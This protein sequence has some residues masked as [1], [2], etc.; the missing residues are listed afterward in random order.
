MVWAA[1]SGFGKTDLY[2]MEGRQN[3]QTYIKVLESNLLPLIQQNQSKGSLFQQNNCP[4]HTAA[5][6]KQWLA[7]NNINCMEWPACSPDL[8]PMENVWSILSGKVYANGQQFHSKAQ[9]IQQMRFCWQNIEYESI[10]A[11][12]TSMKNITLKF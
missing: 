10:S 1:F 12:V 7:I 11:L 8:N 3:S 5:I 6:T 9:L 2:V 4:L